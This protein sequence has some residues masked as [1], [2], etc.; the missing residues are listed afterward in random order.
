MVIYYGSPRKLTHLPPTLQWPLL[1][2]IKWPRETAES[3]PCHLSSLLT[4]QVPAIQNYWWSLSIPPGWPAILVCLELAW[5]WHWNSGI[6]GDSLALGKLEWFFPF[7]PCCLNLS[8]G[9]SL[10]LNCSK[11]NSSLGQDQK[12]GQR[13]SPEVRGWATYTLGSPS[14]DHTVNHKD[15][16]YLARDPESAGHRA[17][18]TSSSE[19]LTTWVWV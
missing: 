16:I 14:L 7:L 17:L 12:K 11:K 13:G 4:L 5:F 6:P 10:C 19:G 18:G 3:W 2:K 15:N 1:V 9:H 8:L